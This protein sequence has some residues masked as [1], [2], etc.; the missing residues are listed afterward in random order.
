[1][2]TE[3]GSAPDQTPLSVTWREWLA[4]TGWHAGKSAP[5]SFDAIVVGSGYGGSVAALRLAQ[6]GYRTLLLERGSEYLP[7]EFPNDFSLVPK[8][9]RVNMPGQDLPVGRASGLVETHVGLGMVAITGNGLGGGSLINAGVVFEPDADVFSQEA[10][11]TAIR[12]AAEGGLRPYYDRALDQLQVHQWPSSMED[13]QRLHK[14]IALER[15]GKEVGGEARPVLATIDPA[16]CV[17]C[18]DCASGCNVDG[19]KRALPA[20]YLRAALATQRVQIVTQ[21]EVH[22]FERQAVAGGEPWWTVHVFST[23]AQHQFMAPREMFHDDKPSA[24]HRC[25]SAPL[26]FL[27]AGTI[28]TT[29]LMQRSQARAEGTCR[30]RFSPVLGTRVSANGDSLSWLV[31]EPEPVSSLGKGEAG[32]NAFARADAGKNYDPTMV[33]GPTITAAIDLRGPSKRGDGSK[34]LEE[35]LMVQDGAVPRAIGPVYRELLATAHG[36][37][38][39]DSWWPRRLRHAGAAFEDPMA[40]SEGRAQQAQ[41]LLTMGHDGS[42]ARLVW[43]D[44]E[45][46]AAPWLPEPEKLETYKRQQS[47]FDRFGDRHV[48]SPLWRLLPRSAEKLMSGPKPPQT[49]TTVHPLGGCVMGDGPD[50]S[51]VDHLGRPWVHDPGQFRPCTAGLG[52]PGDGSRTNADEPHFYRGL[53]VLDGSIVPTSLGCNPLLT[54]TALAERSLAALPCKA[55]PSQAPP[56]QRGEPRQPKAFPSR[57]LSI[58]ATLHETLVARDLEVRGALAVEFGSSRGSGRLEA[59][60]LPQDLQDDLS[61]SEHEMRAQAQLWLGP[62][63]DDCK[64]GEASVHYVSV[65]RGSFR[66]LPSTP[67]SS[68]PFHFVYSLLQLV[69]FVVLA[70]VLPWKWAI[71]AQKLP[72]LPALGLAVSFAVALL[73]AGVVLPFTRS[74][75]TW[76]VLRGC[77]DI[78]EKVREPST[79]WVQRLQDV[80]PWSLAL[81]RQMFH[82]AEKRVMRYDIPMRRQSGPGEGNL[83]PEL[84]LLATK[85]VMYRASLGQVLAWMLRIRHPRG[86][87]ILERARIRPTVWEQ[88]MDAEV[89]L[90]ADGRVLARGTFRMGF[91]NLT[92][93]GLSS[94]RRNAKGPLELGCN[95]DSTT[96]LAMAAGYATLFIR[97]MLKTRLLDFRLP[98]YSKVPRPDVA[99]VAETTLRTPKGTVSPILHRLREVKRGESNS[100]QGGDSTAP[101]D[102]QLWQY[103]QRDKCGTARP[104]QV[105]L[106]SWMGV[107]VAR[108]KAVLLL[109]AFGQSGYSFTVDTVPENLAEHFYNQGYE[110]WILETRMSTRSGYAQEPCTVDQIAA[111]DIPRAVQFIRRRLRRQLPRDMLQGRHLQIAAFAQCIGSAALWMS[112][113]SGKLSCQTQAAGFVGAGVPPQLSMLS[114]AMF[115]QVHPWV[116]GG[117]S[118]Q[119]KTWL[120]AML[121]NLFGRGWVPFAVRGPQDGIVWSTLD[122]LFASMP[123]PGLERRRPDGHD[124]SAATCR[125]IRFIEAPLFRHENVGEKTLRQMSLLFGDANIRLFAHA[126]RFV[127]RERL[128][129]EDGMNRYVTDEAIQRHLAF[130][131]QLLHGK[132]NEL[133]HV[134]SASQSFRLLGGVHGDWQKAFCVDDPADG[135]EALV[136]PGYGHLDVLIGDKAYLDVF[137]AVS[138]FFDRCY[139]RPVHEAAASRAPQWVARPPRLGPFVGWLRDGKKGLRVRV[140]FALEDT[141]S[142]ERGLPCPP[143]MLRRFD[144]QTGT[145]VQWMPGQVEWTCFEA[146]TADLDRHNEHRVAWRFAW[147]DVA[148]PSDLRDP[149]RWQ[150]VSLH[151]SWHAAGAMLLSS[152]APTD[153]QLDAHLGRLQSAGPGNPIEPPVTLGPHDF[154]R[155][156]F[157]LR[158]ASLDSLP[159]GHDVTFAASCCRYPGLGIDRPRVNRTLQEYLDSVR[160]EDTAFALLLGDQIYAD[161]TAGLVDP[162]SPLERYYE[163]HATA[164]DRD[165]LGALLAR[166][167]VYMTPDDHEWIDNY[168]AGSPL[169]KERWPQWGSKGKGNGNGRRRKPEGRFGE[170]EDR[171]FKVAADAITAFERLTTPLNSRRPKPSYHFD[172]GAARFFM[173][174]VRYARQRD[175]RKILPPHLLQKRLRPWLMNKTAKTQL[176][177]IVSGSVVLPGL[178]PDA[179]PANPGAIDTWQ[180]AEAERRELLALLVEMVPGN[181]LLLSG[182]YHVSGAVLVQC[183]GETVGAAI[184]APPLYAPLP[185]ANSTPESV[186]VQEHIALP[187]GQCLDMRVVPHGEFARGSGVANIQV[188]RVGTGIGVVCDRKLWVWERGEQ[189]HMVCELALPGTPPPPAAPV[190]AP[191]FAPQPSKVS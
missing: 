43:R 62:L 144:P 185:Y 162:S 80:V 116:V 53:F 153:A 96:G 113:L 181:F 49:V 102:L 10:W 163:R 41:V 178:R 140:S 48:H 182:D 28:G 121:K 109:H 137:P 108:A 77:R 118:S 114:H 155:I 50:G 22:R 188:R 31:D 107:P 11:P 134:G 2:T 7:G 82:A 71:A 94:A 57:N 103:R 148:L 36:L 9:M 101:L 117:R 27:C 15:L 42:P 165:G 78:R 89:K 130:P 161:A 26:L 100:D 54:I 18:G 150:V 133:F 79:S 74:I 6:K 91:E 98:T 159:E 73:A 170:R 99:P 145:F 139:R 172:H 122:R 16:H 156:E 110:V 149:D 87:G 129:D 32:V 135:P 69:G 143:V 75:L 186:W 8:A 83:P 154:D 191:A 126:R 39:L 184:V 61:A 92:S 146:R 60:F 115:S 63:H 33:V 14:T 152:A 12:R 157:Q 105:E 44:G 183:S 45:D 97:F 34:P 88:V 66:P 30:L 174:D 177:V 35:R 72:V 176:N 120:P 142:P 123:T 21:A 127:D 40:A 37:R 23:D 25:I 38:Q 58:D 47:L 166:M 125:R 17:R 19:A 51:V 131:I 52:T 164:F 128:V 90:V 67:W 4:R 13:G 5:E 56:P 119:A 141:S 95:G 179:D 68:G 64:P 65:G 173:L 20:T 175:S 86:D 85:T 104:P 171:A 160:S 147:A 168:P 46:R 59:R 3:V 190:A 124:D 138:R 187:T 81:L 93:S 24:T 84:R 158:P 136:I 112:L 167:P 55:Q 180:Y 132:E 29:Q 169:I 1:L 70:V 189:A 106:G 151:P 111:H 76:L